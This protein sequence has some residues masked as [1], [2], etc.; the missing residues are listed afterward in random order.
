M[1]SR[2][3]FLKHCTTAGT[4]FLLAQGLSAC[5]GGAGEESVAVPPATGGSNNPNTSTWLMRDEGDKHKATWMAFSAQEAIW[6]S[7]AAARMVRDDLARVANTIVKY[8]PVNMLVRQ[9][10]LAEA[11]QKVDSRVKLIVQ[12][13]DDVWLRDTGPIFVINGNGEKAAVNFNFNGWGKKQT[14]AKD[15][16]IAPFISKLAGVRMLTS[17]LVLE[18]GGIEVDGK[19]TAIITESCVLNPNRNPGMSK[20]ACEAE[21]RDL[22]G[23]RKVIWLPGIVNKDIT[24]AHTDFYARF[25]RPGVIVVHLDTDPASYDKAVTERHLEILKSATDADNKALKIVILEK[26]LKIAPE[27]AN[28]KDFAAGYVNFYVC[29]GAVI[30]PQFGDQQADA[31]AKTRI[32]EAFPGRVIEQISIDG[33]AGGGGGI[34]CVTQQ[35][36]LV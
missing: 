10:D 28:N 19:G 6:G 25:A 36:T 22:L 21:L 18:G 11:Q 29:N 23:I 26:P 14:Y 12:D 3:N 32:A 5:G 8:E 7:A 31:N 2:R 33:I 4:A 1:K 27:N 35:E 16:Q 30:V 15:N 34:H 17:K 20:S 13:M 24:D 9:Q